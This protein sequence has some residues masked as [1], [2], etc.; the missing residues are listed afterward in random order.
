MIS[1]ARI[2]ILDLLGLIKNKLIINMFP[3]FFRNFSLYLFS[4]VYHIT[5]YIFYILL[6]IYY[7]F[8][9]HGLH[10]A[11][12][13]FSA[14]LLVRLLLFVWLNFN[15]MRQN[16]FCTGSAPLSKYHFNQ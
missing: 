15:K 14:L 3:Y 7:K 1:I 8:I 10:T 12:T 11:D 13:A 16:V 4:V 9:T 5:S 2:H 6:Y